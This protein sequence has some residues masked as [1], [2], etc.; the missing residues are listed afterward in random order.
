M[1]FLRL[2]PESWRR[3]IRDYAP[4]GFPDAESCG[5]FYDARSRLFRGDAAAVLEYSSLAV[6]ERLFERAVHLLPPHGRILDIGCGLGH[7]FEFLER[8]GIDVEHYHGIDVSAAMIHAAEDR[9]GADDRVG[10]ELADLTKTRLPKGG[11]DVGYLISVLGYPIGRDPLG[12]MMR[13]L[14]SALDAC[15]EGIAFTHVTGGRRERP[16]AF[17][18][19]PEDLAKAC[20]RELDATA[21]IDD[22][23]IDFTYLI[24]L[25]HR[26]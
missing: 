8:R 2:L 10:F 13:V 23:G 1:S 25:R 26:T 14:G 3:R 21:D 6:Q 24:V 19:V 22:D 12:A 4:R 11:H 7:L 17:P 20:E 5:A 16:L 15:S 18:T 9:L